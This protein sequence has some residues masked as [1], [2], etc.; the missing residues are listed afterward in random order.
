[1]QRAPEGCLSISL[2]N[3]IS[4]LPPT[5]TA[6][7]S[8]TGIR[9]PLNPLDL[10]HLS[11]KR[12][13]MATPSSSVVKTTS[14]PNCSVL[15][16]RASLIAGT[17]TVPPV[18]SNAE[19][20]GDFCRLDNVLRMRKDMPQILLPT[21]KIVYSDFSFVDMLSASSAFAFQSAYEIWKSRWQLP[22]NARKLLRRNCPRRFRN[23]TR[24]F[25]LKKKISTS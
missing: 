19:F 13:R 25:L 20:F 14:V 11:L 8:S 21:V 6:A 5:I 23:W 17:Q 2:V 10:A 16:S 22:N 3:P 15:K 24:K 4:D 7:S 18:K 12:K 9:K 1:M